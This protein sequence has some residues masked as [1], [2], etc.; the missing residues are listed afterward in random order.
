[1]RTSTFVLLCVAALFVIVL[2]SGWRGIDHGFLNYDDPDVI[3]N[4]PRLHAPTVVDAVEVFFEV[5]DHAYLPLY[6]LGLMPEA[7]LFGGSPKAYH[8]GS[9][10]WH[11]LN[12]SL[13]LGFL[14]VLTQRRFLALASALLFALHPVAVESVAWASGRKD[15]VSLAAL[16]IGLLLSVRYFEGPN[17]RRFAGAL[18]LLFAS[19][20]AKGTTVVFPGLLLLVLL[21]LRSSKRVVARP[22]AFLS[23][24]FVLALVSTVVHMKVAA[25]EGTAFDASSSSAGDGFLRFTQAAARYA[26]SLLFP[27]QLSIHYDFGRPALSWIGLFLLFVLLLFAVKMVFRPTLAAL[28]LGWILVSLVPFNNMF[29]RTSIVAADRYL[30]IALPAFGALLAGLLE[31]VPRGRYVVLAVICGVLATLT[32]RRTGDFRDSETVFSQAAMYGP[33]NPLPRAQLAE[34]HLEK[35]AHSDDPAAHI[36]EALTHFSAALGLIAKDGDPVR[37]LR[38]R[39][40]YADT[41]LRASKFEAALEQFTL[42]LEVAAKDPARFGRLGVDP[43]VIR[44]NRAQALLG[45][46]RRADARSELE[47][48]LEKEPRHPAARLTL[49]ALNLRDGF[50][51]LAEARLDSVRDDARTLIT[52]GLVGLEEL[53]SEFESSRRE[54]AR[55]AIDP[56]LEVRTHTESSRALRLSPWVPNFLGRASQHAELLIA[57]YPQRSEGFLVRADLKEDAGDN[58]GALHDLLKAVECAP[59]HAQP[60][61][62]AARHLLRI[63][64]NKRAAEF[65]LAAHRRAPSDPAIRRELS[66]LYAAQ[67]RTHRNA[68][69]VEKS[70]IAAKEAVRFDPENPEAHL[71]VAQTDEGAQRYEEAQKSYSRVLELSPESEEASLGLARY[72]Q[73]RGLSVIAT[74]KERVASA[75]PGEREVLERNLRDLV[76]AE[77][78]KALELAQGSADVAIARRHVREASD[79]AKDQAG[80]ELREKGESELNSGRVEAA[81]EIL[82]QAVRVDGKNIDNHYLLGRALA[83]AGDRQ[84]ALTELRTVIALD[85]EHFPALVAAANLSYVKGDFDDA[86]RHG[87]R[88]LRLGK[89]P[90]ILEAFADEIEATKKLML[91]CER[92]G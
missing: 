71:E 8:V 66:S 12:A 85:P 68:G 50:D 83:Q 24:A 65:L 5:R 29:P 26:Q 86:R 74:L 11:A 16:L 18:L 10:I 78:R 61:L 1:M 92:G 59:D 44:H 27:A 56:D 15:Q 57:R 51:V 87:E 42:A 32:W 46:G 38:T 81:I 53:T 9:L 77:F 28:L 54:R 76:L 35:A 40:R 70:M 90:M 47:E 17:L 36:E 73:A 4:N 19:T 20:F 55:A 60:R 49:Y 43:L 72:H 45:V 25:D 75:N 82:R 79:A 14:L 62:R 7:A 88:V 13:V 2:A 67:A 84:G 64:Q 33:S 58:V 23:L 48:I 41:L 89:D 52:R 30:A 3:L 34:A 69:E 37:V 6:Y 31:R 91:L 80:A 21:W 22:A 63:G 39:L